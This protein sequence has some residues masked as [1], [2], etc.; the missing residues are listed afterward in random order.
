MIKR[1]FL[2]ISVI[3]CFLNTYASKETNLVNSLYEYQ[4][5]GGY[6]NDSK[7]ELLQMLRGDTITFDFNGIEKTTLFSIASP[8]TIWIKK[9]PKKILKRVNTINFIM[10]ITELPMIVVR[11]I[12]LLLQKLLASNFQ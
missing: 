1:F 7:L 8:D 10:Y 2:L 5:K 9:K 4:G 6:S 3:S 11:I 12:I